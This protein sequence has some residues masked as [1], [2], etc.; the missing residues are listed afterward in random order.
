VAEHDITV[1][2]R[3]K[4]QPYMVRMSPQNAR[5]RAQLINFTRPPADE[6]EL[7]IKG[8]LVMGDIKNNSFGIIAN[9]ASYQGS[10]SESGATGLKQVALGSRV[11]AHLLVTMPQGEEPSR[12]G[13]TLVALEAAIEA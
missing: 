1:K 13:F 2:S 10:V 6:E 7:I 9:T 4:K 3:T 8:I 11:L 5:D 12:P